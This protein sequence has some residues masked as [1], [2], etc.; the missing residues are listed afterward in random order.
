M[1]IYLFKRDNF[2]FGKK[3]KFPIEFELKIQEGNYIGIWFE[4]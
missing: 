4:F 1:V 2:P 3:F